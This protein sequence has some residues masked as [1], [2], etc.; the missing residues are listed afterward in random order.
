LIPTTRSTRKPSKRRAVILANG[1]LPD[2]DRLPA[3]TLDDLALVIAADGGL[4]TAQALGLRPH[5]AIGDFDSADPAL[6]AKAEAEGVAIER[7][8]A[9]KDESDLELAVRAAVARGATSIVIVGALGVA[10]VEHTL[11]GLALLGLGADGG[12]PRFEVVVVDERSTIR[13]L[14][15]GSGDGRTASIDIEGEPGDYV[16]LQPWGG[17][18]RGVTTR[19]L[20]YPLRDEPLLMGPSRGLSNELLGRHGRVSCRAGQ[21]LVIHTRRAAVEAARTDTEVSS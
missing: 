5:L 10:R 9:E 4:R 8:A 1:R 2:R 16:S 19:G 3:G 17:D 15:G 18:A 11:A 6:V 14:A 13:L 20:R 12:E 21:L 7:V